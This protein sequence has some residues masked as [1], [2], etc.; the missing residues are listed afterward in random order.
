MKFHY[1]KI[2]IAQL[3]AECVCIHAKSCCN[4]TNKMGLVEGQK[5]CLHSMCV[6]N[7]RMYVICQITVHVILDNPHKQTK[8]K[9]YTFIAFD[10]HPSSSDYMQILMELIMCLLFKKANR[11]KSRICNIQDRN[12]LM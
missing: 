4:K 8:I 9:F 2:A 11:N 7:C 6:I 1:V 12:M 5:F 10:V 3:K